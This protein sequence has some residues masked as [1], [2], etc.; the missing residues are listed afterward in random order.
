MQH[1]IGDVVVLMSPCGDNFHPCDHN[2]REFP[3]HP[4]RGYVRKIKK[5]GSKILLSGCEGATWVTSDSCFTIE[6]AKELYRK[7]MES[8]NDSKEWI[9][10]CVSEL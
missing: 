3:D 9:D 1:K 5:D 8:Y 10:K 2:S 7:T 6:K 4:T